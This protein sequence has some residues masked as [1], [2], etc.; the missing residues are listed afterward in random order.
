VPTRLEVGALT[1]DLGRREVRVEERDVRLTPLEY[2]LLVLLA[3]HAGLVLTHRQ[4][5]REVW[6]Q[7]YAG[8]T[9]YLLVFMA[10]LRKKIEPDP[11][12]PRWLVTE[13]GVGYR[14]REG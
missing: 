2:R 11:A 14:L 3:R 6:G 8:Q 5:L 12:R 7:A 4:I 9:H 10:Q 1:I 13:Q